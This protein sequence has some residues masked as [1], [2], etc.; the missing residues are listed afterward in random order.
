MGRGLNRGGGGRGGGVEVSVVVVSQKH[1]P[2]LCC[3]AARAIEK[4]RKD[5]EKGRRRCRSAQNT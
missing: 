1:K 3:Q 4:F 2:T 5:A